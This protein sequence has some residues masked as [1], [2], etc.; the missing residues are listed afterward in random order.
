MPKETGYKIMMDFI[1]AYRTSLRFPTVAEESEDGKEIIKQHLHRLGE[2]VSEEQIEKAMLLRRG[3][4]DI[5][6]KCECEPDDY[7]E[8][9]HCDYCE[10]QGIKADAQAIA[11]DF[12]KGLG[13]K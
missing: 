5:P 3:I 6:K 1:N 13:I 9:G 2:L 8:G 11:D 4:T 12:R 10:Y 7:I